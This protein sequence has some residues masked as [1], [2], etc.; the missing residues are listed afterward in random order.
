MDQKQLQKLQ[1]KWYKKLAKSGF[2]DI[3]DPSRQDNPLIHWDSIEFQ[4]YWTPDAFVE[5]QRYYELARQMLFD[6]KFKSKRDK[7]IWELHADGAQN[8]DIAKV[9]D[10]HPNWVSKIIKKYASYIKYNT[11]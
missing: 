1:Q 2:K 7:K 8:K 3:E 6:F 9:V 10:L 4:R 11:D 5:K